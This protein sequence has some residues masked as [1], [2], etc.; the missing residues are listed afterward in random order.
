MPG[1]IMG[2]VNPEWPGRRSDLLD[3]LACLAEEPPP[4]SATRADPRWPGLTNAIHWLV[5]DTWWDRRDPS[6]DIGLILRDDA[7]AGAIRAVLGP[8]LDVA[9]RL[10]ADA[11]DAAWFGDPSWREVRE[12]AAAAHALLWSADHAD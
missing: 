2:G 10:T 1:G 4:L 5:D 7:E 12:R 3:A 6:A 11:T 8:L 9:D